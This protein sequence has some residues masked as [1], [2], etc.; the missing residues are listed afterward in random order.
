MRYDKE[1]D[2]YIC[3]G[4]QELKHTEDQS[5]ESKTGYISV[6]KVYQC[7]NCQGCP[8]YGKCYKGKY[9]RR[10]QVS[11]QFDAYRAQSE[12]NINSEE[13]IL[14][15]INRSIQAEGVFGITKQNMGYDRFLRRGLQ[16]VRTEYL[17]LAFGFNLNKLHHRIQDGR[18]GKHLLIPKTMQETA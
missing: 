13:G 5:I 16:G 11:E 18:L 4:G 9:G 7:E 8:Y 6:K 14:L 17:L 12:A 3:K 15:R 1:K 10:I 2:C